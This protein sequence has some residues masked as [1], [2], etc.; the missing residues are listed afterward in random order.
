[1]KKTLI[2]ACSTL[3]LCAW[4]CEE[5]THGSYS[6]CVSS[7][8]ESFKNNSSCG[9]ASVALY[10][11]NGQSIYVFSPGTCSVDIETGYIDAK[12]NAKMSTGSFVGI[13]C[14]DSTFCKNV[15]QNKLVFVKYI[16]RK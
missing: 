9:D 7:Q 1:M 15:Q 10:S 3:F 6:S 16:W 13:I 14:Y 2:I 12:C 5:V 8:I 4:S 11:L